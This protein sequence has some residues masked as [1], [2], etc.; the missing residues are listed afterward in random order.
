MNILL[1]S[2]FR[3]IQAIQNPGDAQIDPVRVVFLDEWRQLHEAVKAAAARGLLGGRALE[4]LSF[5]SAGDALFALDEAAPALGMRIS[6]EDLRKLA[7]IMAPKASGDPLAFN[8]NEDTDLQRVFGVPPPLESTGPLDTSEEVAPTPTASPTASGPTPSPSPTATASPAPSPSASPTTTLTP[9]A[10]ATATASPSASATP[11]ASSTVTLSP[12]PILSPTPA[13]SATASATT[14]PSAAASPSPTWTPSATGTPTS[15]LFRWLDRLAPRKADAAENGP[16]QQLEELAKR[17]RRVVVNEL[18]ALSY[19]SDMDQLLQLTAQR[20]I[21]DEAIDARYR[22]TYVI[23]VKASAWQ[24]SCWRQFVMKGPRIRWL[25]SSTGD[26]GLMQVN[27]HVWRG[28][29]NIKR[30][31]GNRNPRADG[32]VRSRPAQKRSGAESGSSGA[33]GVRR[34]QRRPDRVQS[35]ASARTC[36]PAPNRR[37][38]LGQISRGQEW[39]DDRHPELR[40]RMGSPTRPLI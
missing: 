2:R 15:I 12:T 19:R 8:F 6:A 26:I 1:D 35:M 31:C 13:A 30:Q 16:I 34:V 37:R 40:E 33:I 4:F 28:F 23:L 27:K 9:T 5:I 32:P 29:Y 38:I 25:E 21:A 10:P 14:A 7:H 11:T 22:S 17:L 20:Q 3:L 18:N 36:G 24:E 39:R